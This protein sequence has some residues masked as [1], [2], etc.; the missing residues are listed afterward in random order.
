MEL[1]EAA[2]SHIH[3]LLRRSAEV[4]SGPRAR[5]WEERDIVQS[6]LTRVGNRGL[7]PPECGRHILYQAAL[8][9]G[10]EHCRHLEAA[11][12]VPRQIRNASS[13]NVKSPSRRTK[14]SNVSTFDR[15][16]T[17]DCQYHHLC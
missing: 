7:R 14:S 10:G 8:Q 15:I 2:R 4:P 6:D 1:G 12:L 11:N 3:R 16:S 9:A 5:G 17:E 13:D